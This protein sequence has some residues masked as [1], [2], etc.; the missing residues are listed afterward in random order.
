MSRKMAAFAMSTVQA[1]VARPAASFAK[2]GAARSAPAASAAVPA[3]GARAA[4]FRGTSYG[5]T[6]AAPSISGAAF[7]RSTFSVSAFAGDEEGSEGGGEVK[8]YIGNLDWGVDESKLNE[9]FS[10]YDVSDV[11]VIKDQTSG[12]S[13]G[14]GFVSVPSKAVADKVIGELDGIV[15]KRPDF[16]KHSLQNCVVSCR[17]CVTWRPCLSHLAVRTGGWRRRGG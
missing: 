17:G 10:D 15:S 11:V 12:R 7:Q 14:F 6:A 13:R 1:L 4:A 2:A 8:L 9:V 3:F 5:L 16:P